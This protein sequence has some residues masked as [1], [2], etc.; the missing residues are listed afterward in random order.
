M[1][2]LIDG[3]TE[4][5]HYT[6]SV[7]AFMQVRAENPNQELGNGNGVPVDI[8]GTTYEVVRND[9]SYAVRVNPPQEEEIEQPNL[10]GF[11]V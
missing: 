4:P 6:N 11:P 7:L 3:P 10:E 9:V 1:N 2:L 8:D 5:E